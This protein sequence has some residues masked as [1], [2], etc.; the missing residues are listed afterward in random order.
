V[1]N[2]LTNNFNTKMCLEGGKKEEGT[3][4]YTCCVQKSHLGAYT[5]KKFGVGFT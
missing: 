3:T 4:N 5:V 1:Q 2:L